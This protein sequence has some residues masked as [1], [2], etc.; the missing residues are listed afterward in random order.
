VLSLKKSAQH[1]HHKTLVF[2]ID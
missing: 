2:D 1:R